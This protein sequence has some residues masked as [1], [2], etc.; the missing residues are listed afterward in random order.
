MMIVS[1]PLGGGPAIR[2]IRIQLGRPGLPAFSNL[3]LDA[4]HR[5]ERT[6]GRM[7]VLAELVC[8]WV[9]STFFSWLLQRDDEPN[10]YMGN[11]WQSPKI[12]LK[13]VVWRVCVLFLGVGENLAKLST[14]V[15]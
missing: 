12:H 8:A 14:A 2:I 9:L 11:G 7:E 4:S 3:P 10:L 1:P 15:K 6:L 5:M 13:L